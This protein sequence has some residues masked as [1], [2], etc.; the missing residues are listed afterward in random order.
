V[1]KRH[2]RP[3]PAAPS[4][5]RDSTVKHIPRQDKPGTAGPVT[6]LSTIIKGGGLRPPP[7]PAA[8][9]RCAAVL[10]GTLSNSADRDLAKRHSRRRPESAAGLGTHPIGR[11][12]LPLTLCAPPMRRRASVVTV[13]GAHLTDSELRLRRAVVHRC[14]AQKRIAQPSTPVHRPHAEIIHHNALQC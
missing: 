12:Q 14:S 6:S 2:S 9:G 13:L 10:A 5:S 4:R 11:R 7:A 8:G 3:R 1:S